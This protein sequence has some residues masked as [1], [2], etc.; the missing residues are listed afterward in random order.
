[1]LS[2]RSL[3]QAGATAGAFATTAALPAP[4]VAQGTAAARTIRFI[5]HSNLAAVDPVATSGYIAR[6]YGF[7]VYDTLSAADAEFPIRPRVV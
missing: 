6:N 3:L 1:M 4:A 7:M 5:P 2:R